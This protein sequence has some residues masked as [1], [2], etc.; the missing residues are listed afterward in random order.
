M[1]ENVLQRIEDRIDRSITSAMEVRGSGIS[2]RSASEVMEFAKM[3]AISGSAVPK[4]LR[5]QPGACLGIV[6]D[7]IR[8]EMSPYALAR[9]SYFVNDNL[10]Y[11]AQVLAAI[12]I[13]RAPIKQRPLISFQDEGDKRICIV[14]A[15]FRDGAAREYRSP[16]FGRISPK[17]SPLWKTDPDQQQAYYSLRAFARRHCPDVLLGIY[18]TEEMTFVGPERARDVTPTLASRLKAGTPAPGFSLD[19]VERE[20]AGAPQ[21]EEQGGEEQ[22]LDT[23]AETS[24]VSPGEQEDRPGASAPQPQ[25]GLSSES[26]HGYSQALARA[27]KPDSL[28]TLHEG[29]IRKLDGAPSADDTDILREIYALHVRRLKGEITAEDVALQVRELAGA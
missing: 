9:K 23:P 14:S 26:F 27:V 24:P 12:V 3:M 19:H 18:D 1:S 15:E 16:Q 13:A 8:F 29:F 17:N 22:A 2:F 11:E 20:T 7:A 6:D 10:A 21:D 25:P 28:K 4:H 5:G